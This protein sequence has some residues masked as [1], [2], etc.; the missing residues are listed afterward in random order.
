MSVD[1][2][3]KTD[4]K[5]FATALQLYFVKETPKKDQKVEHFF[6]LQLELH[7][8][9]FKQCGSL[10]GTELMQVAISFYQI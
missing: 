1:R 5:T 3:R 4:L 9:N 10:D 8:M 7:S 2:H 6:Q